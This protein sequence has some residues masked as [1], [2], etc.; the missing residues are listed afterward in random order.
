MDKIIK[1]VSKVSGKIS[2]TGDKSV[3][4]RAAIIASVAKGDTTIVNYSASDEFESTLSCLR[5]YGIEIEKPETE[6]NTLIIHGKGLEGFSKPDKELDAGN[7][8]ATVRLMLGLSAVLP[9]ESTFNGTGRLKT[10]PMLRVIEPLEK[11]GAQIESNNFRA[12]I[13]V[14][15]GNLNAIKYIMPLS[16]SQVKGTVFLAGFFADGNTE[17][18]ERIPSRDHFERLMSLMKIK[19][20]KEKVQPPQPK[21]DDEF[22]RRLRKL[23]RSQ[24]IE[25]RGFLYTLPGKQQPVSNLTLEIP[26]DISAAALFV[27]AA[28]LVKNSDLTIE[29]IGLNPSRIGFLDI[30]SKMR[31]NIKFEANKKM[32][33]EPAGFI[34]ASHAPLKGRRIVGE[35]IPSIIDELP[36]MAIIATQAQGTTVI[37]DAF[38]LRHKET[39]RI[40][41]VVSNLRKMGARIG[42]LEDGMAI[43]GGTDLEG[44]EIITHGDHRIAMAFAMAGLIAK[45]KTIIKDA[46]C[47]VTSHP[48]FWEDLESVV[49]H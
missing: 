3:S 36:I 8:A 21:A 40:K 17:L 20:K 22:E 29:N 41:T 30:L 46:E 25:E 4:H 48:T 43:D 45:G 49:K 13:T 9:F 42:E 5:Q 27:A 11:M 19:F 18:I 6:Q 23:S 33:Y 26:G 44:A 14:N 38:E 16:T 15:G 24:I 12:P 37:R 31:A 7:S 10:R 39:D 32:G 28:I 1:P 34:K 2:F 47:V 35:I